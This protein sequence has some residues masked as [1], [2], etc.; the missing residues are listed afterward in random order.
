MFRSKREGIPMRLPCSWRCALL[1]FDTVVAGCGGDPAAA[2]DRCPGDPSGCSGG[3]ASP[4]PSTGGSPAMP[5]PRS[6]CA[7]GARR[8]PA[9]SQADGDADV[10]FGQ[11]L[12]GSYMSCGI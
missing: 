9:A 4:P 3:G 8:L 11:L 12:N 2:V 5:A 1:V 6:Q 10:G 7:G